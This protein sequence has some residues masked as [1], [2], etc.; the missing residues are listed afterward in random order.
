MASPGRARE[1]K[2]LPAPRA[3]GKA[4]KAPLVRGEAIIRRVL[5]AALEEL[6]QV[7]YQGFR[8]EEVAARAAVN[9]TT[10]YRRWPTKEE[11]V[12]DAL[13][14]FEGGDPVVESTGSLRE[15]M[16]FLAR[17]YAVLASRPLGASVVR[18]LMAESFDP[19]VSAL[20]R[21]LRD[22][23]VAVPRALIAAAAA[24]GELLPGLDPDV[25]VNA[26]AGALQHRIFFMREEADEAYLTSLV[27]LLLSGALSPGARGA[28]GAND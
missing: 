28:K 6:S 2:G 9:K 17:T 19:E 8:I 5:D 3:R 10:V 24:R 20:V 4:Q 25:L 11:L 7:G 23:T 16:L 14:R 1:R 15:D 18:M 21:S 26:M 27:D 22:R 12:R 13:T